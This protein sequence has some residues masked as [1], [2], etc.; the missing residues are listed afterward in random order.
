MT[1]L[2]EFD[3]V[4]KTFGQR[5]VLHGVSFDVRP[6]EVFGL[7]GPNGAGKTTL[8]R[9]LCGLIPSDSG[10]VCIDG[11][12]VGDPGLGEL[13]ELVDPRGRAGRQQQ[14]HRQHQAGS[15][16]DGHV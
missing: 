5:T 15:T 2:A 16:G 9:L 11:L 1:P 7:L 6:G 14:D 13:L 8:V 4:S 3:N 12:D 10:K